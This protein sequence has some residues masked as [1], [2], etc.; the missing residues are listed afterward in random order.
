[1]GSE[2]YVYGQATERENPTGKNVDRLT[3][4]PDEPTGELLLSTY[5]EKT[6]RSRYKS[7]LRTWLQIGLPMCLL[8]FGAWVYFFPQ[9]ATAGR[10]TSF[11]MAL[12]VAFT[13]Y[14]SLNSTRQVDL[15]DDDRLD[16]Y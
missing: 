11:G 15:R 6:L 16:Q 9:A 10:A 13:M 7:Q 12:L 8:G 14:Y 2:L 3:L 5:D 1:M 4:E